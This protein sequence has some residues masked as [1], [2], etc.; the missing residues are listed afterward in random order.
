MSTKNSTS[1]QN[2]RKEQELLAE[3]AELRGKV[4]A[5]DKSQAV[6]E[7]N[8][9][10]T[11]I[12]ANDNFLG[13]VGY[14]LSEIQGQHHSM[15]VTPEFKASQEY[16]QFWESLNR[17]EFESK[18]YKRLAKGG[19]EIWIQASYNPVFDTKG[20]PY[21][22]VKYATDITE[23]VKKNDEAYF[24]QSV[25][26]VATAN[27]M[28]ADAD[29]NITYVNSAILKML[30]ENES[31]LREALPNFNADN[32]IGTNIDQFHAN[33]QH[34]INMLDKLQG[35]YETE[36]DVSGIVFGLS[37]NPIYDRNGEKSG[38][39]V[40]WQDLTQ[41]KAFERHAQEA[42]RI[43]TALDGASTNMMLA[44]GDNN[45]VYMNRSVAEMLK[46]NEQDLRKS[47]RSFDANN[48]IGQN[49]DVFHA[50]P[51]HQ[52]R[53]LS[54]LSDTYN[55]KIKVSGLHFDLIANPIMDEEGNR[56]G[57]SVEWMDIT[58]EVKAQDEI[59]NMI[60]AAG[61]G[62]LTVRLDSNAFDGFLQVVAE[63]LNSFVDAVKSPIDDIIRV[64]NH[65]AD[66]DLTASI[67]E[68]YDGA[69]GELKDS[70]N[71]ASDNMNNVLNQAID[72]A[73]QVQASVGQVRLSSQDLS[74]A[75]QEQSSAVEEVSSS[76]TETNSQVESNAENANVANQLATETADSASDGQQ[77]MQR[78]IDAMQSI[79]DSSNDISKIIKVID[80]IAFQT[81]LL[82][83][84]AAVE[85]ARAGHHGKGFA[86][87][88]QEVR[89][90]AGRSAK[91]AKETADLIE[92]SGN[93]VNEG[94]NIAQET[95]EILTDIVTKILKV[96]DLVAEIAAASDEQTKGIQQVSTAMGQVSSA[97]E[98][99]GQQS[100]ELASA[101]D[102]LGSLIDQLRAEIG[103][104]TIKEK[105]T[106]NLDMSQLPEGITQE[107]L[108]QI[109]Q[110]L[111]AQNGGGVTA[112]AKKPNG[113]GGAKSDSLLLNSDG[114]E[115]IDPSKVMP[116]DADERG[117][118]K[119]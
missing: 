102:Q 10:G 24:K 26:D 65:Q 109:T 96:K 104:F 4:D 114:S 79:S 115:P 116:L 119:F 1:K 21:K 72:V 59:E 113:N 55:A 58:Q 8:M 74:T 67:D 51:D 83:L 2:S 25:L 35:L 95:G 63:G 71:K 69:F 85:A 118:G 61:A 60:Q 45:I 3:L 77:S 39:S 11:I 52:R 64:T 75:A 117:F 48:L 22:V 70:I 92:D 33:P 111:A 101:A 54:D 12:T 90:L 82:A 98:S 103:R 43:K 23:Q 30:K 47:I 53:L 41:Q 76:L 19:R 18:E 99:S 37:V 5:L 88:A 86:V 87:V 57:T 89:N 91:A 27:I 32:L 28:L 49:I 7:F 84:N 93:R 17:G 80:D 107:M 68:D 20:K 110:M 44:D 42:I 46:G 9:D 56:L 66:N 14:S 16:Q 31:Q 97:A 81:N 36:I 78:M 106:S 112:P 6:I 34:Q 29:R 15:F 100:M 62:D 108:M 50:N 94:V 40:E 13:A 38:F 73:G 105:T